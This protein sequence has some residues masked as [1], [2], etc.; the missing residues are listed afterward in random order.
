[1]S[2]LRGLFPEPQWTALQP[3]SKPP[4]WHTK[5]FTVS[6]CPSSTPDPRLGS[7]HQDWKLEEGERAVVVGAGFQDIAVHRRSCAR[8]LPAA[9]LEEG[10]YS[11]RL[12]QSAMASGA[13]RFETPGGA[14][15]G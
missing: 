2:C 15:D 4:A 9:S 10:V 14:E 13:S 3:T 1:M 8:R 5:L 12:E 11:S 6:G 7:H